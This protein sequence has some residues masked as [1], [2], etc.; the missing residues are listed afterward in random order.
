MCS[1]RAR[2]QICVRFKHILVSCRTKGS[3]NLDVAVEV[4][5]ASLECVSCSE[6]EGVITPCELR[7][8]NIRCN[9]HSV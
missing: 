4:M 8:W 6:G 2:W 3:F 7:G 5:T 1:L 9:L